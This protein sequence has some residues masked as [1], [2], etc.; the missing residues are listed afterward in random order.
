MNDG[1]ADDIDR[2]LREQFAGPVQAGD[3]CEQVMDQLPTRRPRS[4]WP[5]A[6]GVSAGVALGGLSLWSAPL[7]RIA[8]H[9]WLSGSLSDAALA[10]LSAM[11]GIAILALAWS[12]AETDDWSRPSPRRI[13]R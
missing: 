5:L 7:T 6:A 4:K 8:W 11:L 3:F 10:L 9:D 1:M 13:A 2:L 12:I